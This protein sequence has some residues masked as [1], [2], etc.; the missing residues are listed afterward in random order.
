MSRPGSFGGGHP[1]VGIEGGR[2]EC[3]GRQRAITPFTIVEGVDPEVA[4]DSEPMGSLPFQ[5]VRGRLE[6]W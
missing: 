3:R 6:C 2:I 5:L 4:K 1:L